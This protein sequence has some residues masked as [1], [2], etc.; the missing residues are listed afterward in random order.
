MVDRPVSHNDQSAVPAPADAF[1]SLARADLVVHAEQGDE[2]VTLWEH[3]ARVARSAWAIA[4][5]PDF[6]SPRADEKALL[7]AALY[8]DAGW[9]VRFRAH[10]VTRM[11]F[12]SRP[13]S[14][15]YRALGAELMGK[16]LVGVIPPGVLE[17]ATEAIH[18]LSERV[19]P[20]IE[21]QIVAEAEALEEFGLPMLWMSMRRGLLEGKGV[22]AVLDHWNR[23]KEYQYWSSRLKSA[24]RVEAVREVA[25]RRLVSFEQWIQELGCQHAGEDLPAVLRIAQGSPPTLGA[26]SP[27]RDIKSADTTRG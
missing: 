15:A 22:R 2:D 20:T 25:R 10:E 1:W 11:E 3:S 6:Q 19:P 4:G 9:I 21:A 7:A 27:P 8:H 14:A 5:L 16:R 26:S 24:F 23:R 13:L 17:Q 18:G 12:L